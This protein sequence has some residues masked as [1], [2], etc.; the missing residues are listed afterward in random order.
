M[1]ANKKT[2]E[3]SLF[4][5]R[6]FAFIRGPMFSYS[7]SASLFWYSAFAASYAR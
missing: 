2:K 6:S 3:L 7:T 5:S 4:Y 1:N